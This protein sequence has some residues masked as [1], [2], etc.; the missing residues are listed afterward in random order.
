MVVVVWLLLLPV[1]ESQCGKKVFNIVKSEKWLSVM[2][3]DGKV[4]ESELHFL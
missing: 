4:D 3:P 2:S 1:R